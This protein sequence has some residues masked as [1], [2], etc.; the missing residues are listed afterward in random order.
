MIV[1]GDLVR[2]GGMD[3]A[4]L[5]LAR[6]LA[7]AGREV[8]L[9]A[10]RVDEE[11]LAMPGVQWHRV[12]KPL[13]SYLLGA[14]ALARAGRRWGRTM[15]ARGG[16]TVVN[17]GNCAGTDANWVHYV[18][19]GH[20]PEIATSA[21]RRMLAQWKHRQYVVDERR[22]LHAA[23]V[24]IANSNATKRELVARVGI[25]AE[26]VHT[27]YY[28]ADAA[29]HRPPSDAER[30]DARKSLGWQDERPGVAF[31][32][33][34]GDRR[35]GFDVLFAA[36]RALCEDRAWDARLVIAGAGSELAEWRRTA[37]AAGLADRIHFLGFTR[38]VRRVLWACDAIAAPARYEAY[39]LAV[40]E[41]VCCG[42]PAIT[43]PDA[44]VAERL[45]GLEGLQPERRENAAALAAALRRWHDDRDRWARAARQTSAEL[46]AWSWDDMAAQ[47]VHFME[48]AA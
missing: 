46:R 14:R 45:A 48:S 12:A 21:G 41:A 28:G 37:E 17:G 35:K 7:G 40:H 36:W 31:V 1:T 18:H 20:R 11:L 30:V 10:H 16:H 26:R 2:T 43:N 47:I 24:V 6:Y 29:Y 9:V 5:H 15:A 19:A 38:D 44:G 33:A 4:N 13:D 42:L 8:H 3:V 27:V 34:L 22:A 25:R 39:G 23:R 32:G